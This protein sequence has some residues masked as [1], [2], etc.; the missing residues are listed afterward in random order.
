MRD[1]MRRSKACGLLLA[2]FAALLNNACAVKK[3]IQVVNR[4][5]QN[6]L[7]DWVTAA[8]AGMAAAGHNS[9]LNEVTGRN[10]AISYSEA[11]VMAH[12]TALRNSLLNGR[13]TT[14]VLFDIVELGLTTAVPISNGAR[15]KTILGS[16]ATGLKGTNLSI[17]RNVFNEQSTATILSA[18]DTCVMR[19]R[20]AIADKSALPVDQYTI[21]NGYAELTRLYGCTTLAG[22]LQELSENQA[23]AAKQEQQRT[24]IAPITEDR[25][26]ELREIQIAFVESVNGDKQLALAFLKEMKVQ[27]LTDQSEPKEFLAAYRGLSSILGRATEVDRFVAAARRSKLL[28]VSNH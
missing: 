25:L 23:I 19:Q 5:A 1:I 15:G 12:Y 24:V 9:S 26:T 3:P 6:A 8:K 11:A 13:A 17:D 4:P 22:A 28:T 14:K 7:S 18:M 2:A 27:G 21:Y 16:L 20:K 10:L